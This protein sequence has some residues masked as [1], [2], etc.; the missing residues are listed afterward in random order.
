MSVNNDIRIQ[1]NQDELRRM[2]EAQEQQEAQLRAQQERDATQAQQA[3]ADLQPDRV[4]TE[5]MD[6]KAAEDPEDLAAQGIAH[7]DVQAQ[8]QAQ[9]VAAADESH[10]VADAISGA[11]KSERAT[12]LASTQQDRG[13]QWGSF[14]AQE[15][16][17]KLPPT[18]EQQAAMAQKDGQD[19]QQKLQ[20][21]R[22]IMNAQKI[23]SGR[24]DA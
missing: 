14:N 20:S 24:F 1:Q 17:L 18:P 13:E 8:V 19:E 16:E 5:D 21:L 12:E 10:A 4:N 22:D 15:R 3:A 2:Q 23:Q 6:A 11:E 9:E 7:R